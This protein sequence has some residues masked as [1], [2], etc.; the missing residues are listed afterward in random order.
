MHKKDGSFR[1]SANAMMFEGG[2]LI[3]AVGLADD[4]AGDDGRIATLADVVS[5]RR[6]SE[7]D[8]LI[9]RR[10][11]VTATAEYFGLSRS[12]TPIIVVAHGIGPMADPDGMFVAYYGA[13]PRNGAIRQA[14]FLKLESGAYG[15]VD[16]VP[17]Q[18]VWS[19]KHPFQECLTAEQAMEDPLIR[20]R[21]GA[22]C[23]FYLARH[24][25]MTREH[26]REKYLTTKDHDC[27]IMD[28]DPQR[29]SYLATKPDGES[30]AAHL[31]SV[32]GLIDY[33]HGHWDDARRHKC[34]V[35]FITCHEWGDEGW[36]IGWRGGV[37]MRV[38]PGPSIVRERFRNVW[39]QLLRTGP[40]PLPGSRRIHALM[41]VDGLLF[42][43]HEASGCGL[44]G[45]EP[46]F[47]VMKAE[48]TGEKKF[49]FP[50]VDGDYRTAHCDAKAIRA[51]APPWANAFRV[52]EAV[53]V[54][55]GD[56]PTHHVVKVEYHAIN[57]GY[58]H[59]VPPMATIERDFDLLLSLEAP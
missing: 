58:R 24:W 27:M 26:A 43:R 53:P 42:T 37:R 45:G 12:G 30:A 28:K 15:P 17:L 14:E 44:E 33:D 59:R 56:R 29:Q 4:F 38:H 31:L 11:I 57:L 55:D 32:S 20:A 7:R 2:D 36:V 48:K 10:P 34:L 35:S 8:D 51:E 3:S 22:D 47:P 23:D 1:S 19:R 9:W 40:P 41:A 39:R 21:L 6:V 52:V 5:E 25:A 49:R 16:I 18:T 50:A 46:E 13:P 54:W